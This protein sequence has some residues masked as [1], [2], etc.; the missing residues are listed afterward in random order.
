MSVKLINPETVHPVAGYSH[1]ARIGDLV[2]VSGQI[3]KNQQ[4]EIVAKGDAGA[5]TE[6]VYE[7]LRRVLE[8]VGSGL[9]LV[10]KI[11]VF[12]TSLDHRPAINAVRDR[13]FGEINHFPAGT[14]VVVKSLALP[15]WVVEIEAIAV[16]R[17]PG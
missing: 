6:L 4:D 14:F 9:D 3:S 7:N 1:V 12:T 11:T 2:F 10:G 8:A 13:V 5:Q 15:D 16:V 17:K